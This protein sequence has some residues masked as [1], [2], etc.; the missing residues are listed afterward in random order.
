M[1]T[2]ILA[3]AVAGIAA[4]GVYSWMGISKHQAVVDQK[5]ELE[6]KNVRLESGIARLHKD[7]KAEQDKRDAVD[8]ELAQ[9]N[10]ELEAK[11]SEQGKVAGQLEDLETQITSKEK[12]IADIQAMI[13]EVKG[14][15]PA[16]LDID[17]LPS[18]IQKLNNERKE[19]NR[20][21]EEVLI[22]MEEAQASLDESKAGLADLIKRDAERVESL[23]QNSISSLITAVNNDW[24]FVIIKPHSKAKI[25]TDSNLMVVRGSRPLA[26]LNINAV[27]TNRVIADIDYDSLV[28]G[29]RLRAGD[30]V[31]LAKPN[32][33]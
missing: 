11:G 28:E 18:F 14:K 31:I 8:A 23:T 32:M 1:K 3:V 29:A 17:A 9:T 30:R 12:E 25:T 2:P 5:N 33:R 26:R 22:A 6:Q 20:E 19:L 27:E 7:Y 21:Y 4:Y 15:L 13:A 16:D 10:A 24:G